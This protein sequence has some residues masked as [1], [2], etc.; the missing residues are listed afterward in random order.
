MKKSALLTVPVSALA[1]AVLLASPV[2]A[3]GSNGA[4][5]KAPNYQNFPAYYNDSAHAGDQVTH[6]DV[7]VLDKTW[8]GYEYWAVYTP[9]VM[10]TSIYENP[11]IVASHDGL[12]WETP[13]GLVNPI[14]PQPA[15]TRYH[16]CDADMV[17]NDEM[18]AMM[19]YWNWADDM[20]GGDG[21]EV[22]L[23]I[24]YDGVHWGIPVTYDEDSRT[25][26][27]PQN[28]SE[29]QVRDGDTDYITAI[30]S[31]DRYDMLSPTFVYDAYRD[32]YIMWANNTGDV[33]YQ[34]GQSNYVRICYSD[35]GI[36]WGTPEPVNNFLGVDQ[37]GNQLAPWHQDVQY[38]EQLKEFFAV[39]QCFAGSTPDGSVLHLTKSK[40]G[41]NWQQVGTLPLLSPGE[42]GRWDD[43]QIYRS[44]MYFEDGE[45]TETSKMRV[46]YAALQKE[47]NNKLV[48]DLEGNLTIQATSED[49]R[50]WRIGYAENNYVD[51]MR[52]LLQDDTYDVPAIIAGESLT[53]ATESGESTLYVGDTSRVS[54][55]FLP[56]ST[57]DQ[58]VKYTS[59]NTDVATVDNFGNVIAV[60]VGEATIRGETRESLHDELQLTV[61]KSQARKIDQSLMSASATSE[62]GGTSEGPAANVLDGNAN[63]IWHTKY[64]PQVALPQSLIVTLPEKMAVTR[65]VYTPRQV[66][67]N[68]MV[69]K[70]ELY[71]V[72]EDGTETCLSSGTWNVDT[73]DKVVNF[74]P[75][76]AR[77]LKLVVL[78]GVG[79]FGTAA[80]INVYQYVDDNETSEVTIEDNNAEVKYT[81]AWH[82]DQ[83]DAFSGNTAHYTEEAGATVSLTFTGTEIRWYGQKDTNF[84]T[85][86]VYI[87][88]EFVAT[89][90]VNG[91][92]A[93]KQL[94]FE[95]QN[96]NNESHTITIECESPVVDID[97]F[98]Y[99][100]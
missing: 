2:H 69:T 39:S 27:K 73:K 48:A 22:R 42:T 59:S 60:G 94:L 37:N 33:G 76:E 9:N 38:V 90:D 97:Y 53:I 18:D 89:V 6:P 85:A 82:N 61:K 46:W 1:C 19:A 62:H 55:T 40:D 74:E 96:L 32:T 83:N 29:R 58:V 81:G 84:G 68:G 8:N 63:T 11:S 72:E 17:Y 45:S 78:E 47:T 79:G 86:K 49:D 15:S 13:E 70:Y 65:Y 31:S 64:N 14:E 71:A 98:T 4:L 28:N 56:E 3:E 23:R 24:S 30:H 77:S 20:Y 21:A 95:K 50:I 87:D 41:V 25:W 10:R 75:T 12:T 43:F 5:V 80:E 34:N 66:G 35:D 36:N 57:S 51:M 7:V 93:S 92:M 44:C 54:C 100:G 67:T 91:N 99:V 52:F 88:G 26:T 16:N